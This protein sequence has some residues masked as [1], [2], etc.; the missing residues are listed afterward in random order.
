MN[1]GNSTVFQVSNNGQTSI[2]GAMA[3]SSSYMLTV[4][5]K[6][7]AREVKVTLSNP[8]PD[9]VFEKKYKLLSLKELENYI[10]KNKHLPGIPKAADLEK[11]EI[12]LDVGK[13]QTVQMEKI[14]EIYLHL[15]ELNKQIEELKK[16]NELLKKQKLK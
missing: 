8:W 13:M 2:G 16:E 9:Y 1:A 6:I 11:D 3:T 12:G 15:I 4:N 10:L 7:G 5:G 14:E